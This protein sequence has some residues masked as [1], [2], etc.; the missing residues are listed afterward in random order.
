MIRSIRRRVMTTCGVA[1]PALLL[2]LGFGLGFTLA[3]AWATGAP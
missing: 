1:G 2:S 3:A